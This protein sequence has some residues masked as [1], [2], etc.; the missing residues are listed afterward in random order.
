M[1]R[2]RWSR[3]ARRAGVMTLLAG[4]CLRASSAEVTLAAS[5]AQPGNLPILVAQEQRYFAAEGLTVRLLGCAFGK[6]CLRMVIE[7]TAQFATVADL[8]IALAAQS[9]ERFAVLATLNK[10]RNDTKIVARRSAGIRN[11]SDLAGRTVGLYRGTT[12]QYAMESLLVIDGVDPRRLTLV[13]LKPGEG[14]LRLLSRSIDAAALFEPYAF[15]AAQ[16]LGDDAL[17][18]GTE[19]I[20][21]QTWNLVMQSG[22]QAPTDADAEALLRALDR[23]IAWIH[24]HPAEAR[25]LLRGR[26]E[27]AADFVAIHWPSMAFELTLDQALLTTLEGESRW[28]RRTGLTDAPVPNFLGVIRSDLLRRVRP[29]GA[30][31]VD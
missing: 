6:L 10:N 5:T 31:I 28:A 15:E 14:R 20:Y 21:T 27:S 2:H 9:G 8:P 25:A 17:V 13:D 7:G 26:G 4:A 19:R 30:R 22:P 1:N 29:D 12:A 23:A 11:A 16:A 24:A 18:L 3:W